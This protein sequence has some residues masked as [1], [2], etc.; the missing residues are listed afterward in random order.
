MKRLALAGAL[1]SALVTASGARAADAPRED[2][3]RLG[4]RSGVALPF[5]NAFQE[6]GA[7]GTTIGAMVPLRLDAGWRLTDHWTLGARG[8]LGLLVGTGCSGGDHCSGSD[9]RVGFAVTYDIA[10][11]ATIDAWIG[12]GAGWEWLEWTRSLGTQSVSLGANGPELFEIQ[13]G[14]DF[15]PEPRFRIGPLI[16]A[17]LGRFDA[18][19]LDGETT[20]DFAA[21]V[22]SWIAVGVRGAY[23]IGW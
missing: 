14:L 11:A 23:D 5:G 16:T 12:V 21:M 6:S 15:R 22:H 17:S 10:P 2:P 9:A 20:H 3:L 8:E 19:T 13:A 4:L 7:L 18:I 1:A